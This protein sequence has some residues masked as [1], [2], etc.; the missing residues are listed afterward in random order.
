MVSNDKIFLCEQQ[1]K[2]KQVI[3]LQVRVKL[4]VMAMEGYSP[5]PKA[6]ALEP[7]YQMI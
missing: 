1:M 6:P 5:F 7:Q 2:P 3:P 4:G